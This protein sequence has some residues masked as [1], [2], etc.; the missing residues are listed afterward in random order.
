MC[1]KG[2]S[3]LKKNNL[4]KKLFLKEKR[5][6]RV[7]DIYICCKKFAINPSLVIFFSLLIVKKKKK[8]MKDQI[9]SIIVV[10][11]VNRRP[12]AS[13]DDA[14]K[15]S[16]RFKYELFSWKH[17]KI[18]KMAIFVLVATMPLSLVLWKQSHTHTF[19]KRKTQ[20]WLCNFLLCWMQKFFI[21]VLF[22][23]SYYFYSL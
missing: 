15:A 20:T 19:E 7:F 9:M 4:T 8:T 23:M 14:H 17:V 2:C 16:S 11:V 1:A 5:S 6:K 3:K 18:D 21:Y 12:Y 13:C 22:A 10:L